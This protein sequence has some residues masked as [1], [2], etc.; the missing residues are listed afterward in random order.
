MTCKKETTAKPQPS[1]N[2][3]TAHPRLITVGWTVGGKFGGVAVALLFPSLALRARCGGVDGVEGVEAAA[4]LPLSLVRTARPSPGAAPATAPVGRPSRTTPPS[5][6][7]ALAIAPTDHP[8]VTPQLREQRHVHP[9]APT[10]HPPALLRPRDRRHDHPPAPLRSQNRQHGHP[11]A[12][13]GQTAITKTT[14]TH[15]CNNKRTR[16]K[17]YEKRHRARERT[18]PSGGLPPATLR[19]QRWHDDHP[20]APLRPQR[21][22]HANSGRHTHPPSATPATRTTVRPPPGAAPVGMAMTRWC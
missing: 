13:Q 18:N 11:Q 2:C 5:P 3:N 21:Q 12:P 16:T 7:A 14:G 17:E 22:G 20:P 6:G 10:C 4:L 8:P 9:S 19:P 1:I 15:T